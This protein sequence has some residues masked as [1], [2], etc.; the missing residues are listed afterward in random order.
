MY[1]WSHLW[2]LQGEATDNPTGKDSLTPAEANRLNAR[3]Q[4]LT[5]TTLTESNV[6]SVTY[7]RITDEYKDSYTSK[8]VK[9]G[10]PLAAAAAELIAAQAAAAT[11][12]NDLAELETAADTVIREEDAIR[13][14]RQTSA[15]A[16]QHLATTLASLTTIEQL[17]ETQRREKDE[18]E[19]AEEAYQQLHKGD[20]EIADVSESLKALRQGFASQNEEIANL[21]SN[22]QRM[23]NEVTTAPNV[24]SRAFAALE[25]AATTRDL[26]STLAR[27]FDLE[28]QRVDLETKQAAIERVS[29]K[30]TAI[31]KSLREL[32]E[33]DRS[34]ISEL[35]DLDRQR[36]MGVAKLEAIATR[37]EVTYA[38]VAVLIEGEQLT[39]G[40][41]RT[42]ADAADLRIG[43]GTTIR[44]IPGGGSR[45]PRCG[46]RSRILNP[47]SPGDSRNWESRASRRPA[48]IT[49]LVWLRTLNP[50]GS[51]KRFLTLAASMWQ[52]CSPR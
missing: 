12:A 48:R 6:D 18:L 21:R 1:G 36:Q 15:I 5:G 32:P 51:R 13:S 24:T 2:A 33:V 19:T 41:S 17:E 42:L 7:Q 8:G 31:E 25:A 47:V 39:D 50:H 35:E 22:E 27:L 9:A 29:H 20:R 4:S 44:I 16:Q 14:L 30:L 43:E 34:T 52:P 46:S 45:S 38:D 37:L 40:T 3:L 49:N 10:S 28:T 23:Q 26:L 11:A